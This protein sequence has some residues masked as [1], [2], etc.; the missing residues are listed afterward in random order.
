MKT[1]EQTIQQEEEVNQ[2]KQVDSIY[3]AIVKFQGIPKDIKKTVENSYFKN[4]Y[5]P[6]SEILNAIREP[7]L[8]CG[9]AIMQFPLDNDYLLTRV[10]HESGESIESKYQ[11]IPSDRKPQSK[12]S[13]L[14]YQKRYAINAILGLDSDEDDDGNEA[15]KPSESKGEEKPWLNADTKEWKQVIATLEKDPSRLVGVL[16]YYRISANNKKV[17]NDLCKK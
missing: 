3:K 16:D 11:M 10:I 8:E 7:L 1:E 5:A 17:L 15:S 4:K 12:G 9:L 2:S 14:T 13:C 6:L